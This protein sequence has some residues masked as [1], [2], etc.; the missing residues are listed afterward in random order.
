MSNLPKGH[1]FETISTFV[2]LHMI[3]L[4]EIKGTKK[5]SL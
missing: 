2:S 4:Q 3:A 5:N 1:P